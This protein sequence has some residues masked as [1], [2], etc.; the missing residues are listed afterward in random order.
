MRL[1]DAQNFA[2]VTATLFLPPSSFC[3]CSWCSEYFA[4]QLTAMKITDIENLEIDL[5]R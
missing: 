3:N 5:R 2:F 4:A 1:L